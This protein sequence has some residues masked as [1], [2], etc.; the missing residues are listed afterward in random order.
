MS[1]VITE[2][3]G[4]DLRRILVSMITD[5]VVCNRISTQWDKEGLFGSKWANL[6][7]R[8][9]VDYCRKYGKVPGKNIRPIFQEWAQ[10]TNAD[11]E[12]IGMIEKFIVDLWE[13]FEHS[14]EDDSDYILDLARQYFNKVRV[15]REIEL[16]KLELEA[17]KVDE[18]LNRLNSIRRIELGIGS[19]I[20][21]LEDYG[22]WSELTGESVEL[23]RPLVTYNGAVGEWLDDSFVRGELYSY[24]A[25]DKCGKTAFLIDFTYRALRRRNRVVYIDA[26]DSNEQEIITLLACRA[27]YCAEY[28]GEYNFP[29][30][31]EDDGGGV[32]TIRKKVEGLDSVKSFQQMRKVC[33]LST[34]FRLVCYPNSS[35][36]AEGIDSLID[37]WTRNGWRPDIVV[38]DYADILASPRNSR[39]ANEAIDETWKCLR[40]ITQ[41][42]RCLMVTATQSSALAYS[43]QGLLSRKHFSGRKTKLAH[44]NGMI[45]INV[46]EQD[47]QNQ[48]ARLNWIVRRR[49]RNRNRKSWVRV[50]GCFDIARPIIIS[51]W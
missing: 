3:E 4:D 35:I 6:V 17:G 25:P 7:G 5:H 23:R 11:D 50:A 16:A 39:D 41:Q 45:G 51:K 10:K 34:M 18:S 44:V 29:V 22:I 46:S 42:R 2:Y 31:W 15:R 1:P 40:R 37:N 32:R 36:S 21:P 13:E 14:E 43:S 24:M 26:G 27:C 48:S 47:R 9:C 49:V 38:V 8:W 28:E 33:H 19:F 20:E 12:T 30:G